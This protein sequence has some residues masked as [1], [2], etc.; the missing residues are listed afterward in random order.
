L[1]DLLADRR[2]ALMARVR[3]VHAL[4]HF[5]DEQARHALLEAA[6][7]PN[8]RVREAVANCRLA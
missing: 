7:D 1:L 2:A 3:A 4:S 8:E 5:S 6:S